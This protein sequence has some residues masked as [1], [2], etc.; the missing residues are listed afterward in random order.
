MRL[1][2][3]FCL[4]EVLGEAIAIPTQEA[5]HCLSGIASMNETG[6]FLFQLL[7]TEQTKESLVEALM[8]NYEVDAQ[9]AEADVTVF[10]EAL[11]RNRLI[12]EES[13]E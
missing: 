11:R 4:R 10:I 7:Q 13:E 1:I 9:S 3:G 12:K 5:A 6:K 8:D 2:A